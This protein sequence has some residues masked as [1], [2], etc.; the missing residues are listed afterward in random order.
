MTGLTHQQIREWALAH[1]FKG[2]GDDL[3]VPYEDAV[4]RISFPNRNV[5]VRIEKD[6]MVDW[7]AKANPANPGI[8]IDEHGMLVGIGLTSRFMARSM[9]TGC[10][11]PSWFPEHYL[12]YSP[13]RP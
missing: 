11:L 12:G 1:G 8:R 13:R 7:L 9:E 3:V 10:D 4:L 5:H 6:G 2:E